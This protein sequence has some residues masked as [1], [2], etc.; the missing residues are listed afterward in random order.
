MR[1]IDELVSC[2]VVHAARVPDRLF[3]AMEARTSPVSSD[4]ARRHPGCQRFSETR[5]YRARPDEHGGKG[6][7]T[8][9]LGTA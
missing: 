8:A 3:L 7:R 5:R 9:G 4:S 2:V 1:I 6:L